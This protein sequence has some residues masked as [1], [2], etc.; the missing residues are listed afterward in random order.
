M[1]RFYTMNFF[2]S[3]YNL[4]WTLALGPL[5]LCS[6]VRKGFFKR[7]A[8]VKYPQV[9]LIVQAA[10]VGEAKL[11]L[12][13]TQKL[14]SI[15]P[16]L[17]ILVTTQTSEAQKILQANCAPQ[18]IFVEYFPF[19]FW[20]C[21][22]KFLK[23][24]RPQLVL[25]LETEIWP[26][27]YLKCKQ[28]NIPLFIVN[29]RMRSKTFAQYL[30]VQKIFQ[31]ISPS[32]IL[33]ISKADQNRFQRIFP[34]SQIST[35]PNLKFDTIDLTSPISYTQNP[36]NKIIPPGLKLIVFGSIRGLEENAILWVIKN[37]R[38]Q[39]PKTAI[40]IFPRHLQRIS[41]LRAK[42][43]QLHLPCTLRT[44][45]K[46]HIKPGEIILWD[47][48]GEL[49]P[50]Y[51]LAH[52]VFVGGT[53]APLGG[54]NFLEPLSQGVVPLIGPYFENFAWIGEDIFTLNLVKKIL[55]KE[56]LFQALIQTKRFQRKQ[57]FAKFKQYLQ[58]KQGGLNIVC[59]HVSSLLCNNS[60]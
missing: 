44:Q 24:T 55:N 56:E 57:V 9:D 50:A 40:A 34:H 15:H 59:E 42:L 36:L 30:I 7:L 48:M 39:N 53:L 29:A 31:K 33:A 22:K 43:H 14:L 2:F 52:K 25:I 18:N 16:D 28:K 49:V 58:T 19:D 11:A 20:P 3:L 60:G 21:V 17:K 54:Q 45:I 8:L 23:H 5:L 35:M 38:Q 51:A 47:Q 27:F 12:L 13:I 10:S 37:L 1:N 4:L 26:N 46:D 32:K 6:R 41:N